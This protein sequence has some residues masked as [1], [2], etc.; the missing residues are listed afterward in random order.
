MVKIFCLNRCIYRLRNAIVNPRLRRILISVK[1]LKCC[2]FLSTKQRSRQVFLSL[3]LT[4]SVH[5]ECINLYR[6]YILQGVVSLLK[7]FFLFT[8][9]FPRRSIQS[10]RREC[11]SYNLLFWNY[12]GWMTYNLTPFFGHDDASSCDIVLLSFFHFLNLEWLLRILIVNAIGL[13]LSEGADRKI[14]C[15]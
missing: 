11:I 14:A 1:H 10:R 15:L 9:A 6:V 3:D 7:L 5:K 4:Y 13:A 12:S 8:Y 2:A